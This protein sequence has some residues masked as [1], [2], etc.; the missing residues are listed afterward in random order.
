MNNLDWFNMEKH[1]FLNGFMGAGKSKVGP[2]LAD[3]LG[4]SWFDI[5]KLIEQ[6]TGKKVSEIFELHGESVFRKMESDTIKEMV[7]NKTPCV[8]SLG[9]GALTDPENKKIAEQQGIVVYLKSSPEIIFE[10]VKNS[11]KRPLLNIERDE[12]FEKNLLKR[13]KEMLDDRKEMYESAHLIINRDNLKPSQ[14]ADNIYKE[15]RNYEKNRS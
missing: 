1:I 10:R 8:I 2:L 6:K 12:N 15:L 3:L 13:I 4:C 7:L 5:D 9:G 11:T 14:V